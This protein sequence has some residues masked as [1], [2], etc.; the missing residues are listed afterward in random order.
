M[1]KKRLHYLSLL[2]AALMAISGLTGCEADTGA[3]S[4]A[5]I[6]GDDPGGI[7]TPIAVEYSSEDMDGSWDVSDAT[8]I[9]LKGSSFAVDGPGAV[10][11]GGILTISAAGT[12]VFSGTLTDGRI[13]VD[14]GKEDTVRLV[15]NNADLSC[16]DS[17]P[18]YAKQAGKTILTLAGGTKNTVSDGAVYSYEEGEDEPDAAIFSKDDLTINGSGLLTVNGNFNNGIGAKDNLV[19]TGGSFAITAAKDGLRGRDSIAINGG[20]FDIEAGGDAI[21]SNNDEDGEKGWVSLDG[22]VFTL[23]AGSDGIQ[24]ETLLQ[25]TAGE[26]TLTTG[27]GSANASADNSG[28][29]RPEWGQRQPAPEENT[30]AEDTVSAKGLKAGTGILIT[31]GVFNIDSSDDAVH[32]NGDVVIKSGEFAISSGDDG[33]HADSAL[34]VD[35]GSIVIAQSYEGLEGA[36][37]TVNDGILRLTARD[38]GLN[39]SGGDA[40]SSLGGGPGQNRFG[41]SGNYFIRI[42]GG[43]LAI[44]AS[45]DGIDSNGALYFDGG[46][47]LVNGPTN[48][49]NGP[50][51]YLGTCEV[52]GGILAIA[53]S[54]GM[55]QAPGDTSAQNSLMV[56]YASTQKAGTLV[57]LADESGNSVLSFSPSKDY[58]SIVISTPDLEQGRTYTL[59]SGGSCDGE[60]DDGLYTGGAYSGGVK[61]TDVTLYERVT[62]ISDSGAQVSGRMGGGRV[63]P[64]GAGAARPSQRG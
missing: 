18:I 45:G 7:I 19:I 8:V 58:Q 49:G 47:V 26:F 30:A 22:G 25:V 52:T 10:A 41:A 61:L 42:T 27:G 46:T 23:T 50:L 62:T 5:S 43:Y 54:S 51:D 59:S 37:I 9:A 64:G 53:G 32:A 6:T 44:D 55:A 31:G 1:K 3:A 39:A 12:Y 35:G 24:A 36:S 57:N 17:A 48:S 15:L 34:T 14:A 56:Y 2:M 33:I 38:D 40:D 16:L 60:V 4:T 20:A 11:D 63:G 28:N 21:Q 13:I 29:P